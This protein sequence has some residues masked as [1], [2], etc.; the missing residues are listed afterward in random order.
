LSINQ[1]NLLSGLVHC[2]DKN[3]GYSFVE[4]FIDDQNALPIKLRFKYASVTNFFTSVM[5][6]VQLVFEKNRDCLSLSSHDRTNLLRNTIE[7]N[8][9]IGGMFLLRQT[10]LLDDVTFFTSAEIIFHSSTMILI[11]RIID[12]FD[13]D[14][15]FSKII[16]AT[17]AFTSINYTVYKKNVRTNLTN[18][19]A[20]LPIQDMYTELAW[21]YLLHKYGEYQAVIRFS[22]LI[23][24]LLLVNDAIVEAHESQQYAEIIDSVIEQTEQ[25]LSL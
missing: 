8:G 11:K 3:S 20:I 21:R 9:I 19:K 23:R 1:W 4:Q 6:K 22:K 7:Y 16:L 13:T 17:L 10:R 12:L 15:T 2:F 24:C 18:I 14:D 25:A 5:G